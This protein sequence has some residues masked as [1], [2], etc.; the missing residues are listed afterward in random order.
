MGELDD[1]TPSFG[2]LHPGDEISRFG[3]CVL[4]KCAEEDNAVIM[5]ELFKDIANG[6]RVII[7]KAEDEADA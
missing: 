1:D 4:I 6:K 7:G 5:M 2:F 3:N